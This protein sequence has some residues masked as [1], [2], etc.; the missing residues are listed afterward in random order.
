MF[1]LFKEPKP[2]LAPCPHEKGISENF[3]FKMADGSSEVVPALSL[4]PGEMTGKGKKK[5]QK[6]TSTAPPG[7]WGA[8]RQQA[9]YH[10]EESR[11]AQ[12]PIIDNVV[13]RK[14]E[15]AFH[16]TK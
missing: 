1:S 3:P 16:H 6:K 12:K 5:K 2:A 10:R 14:T 11:D 9:D 7:A 13:K 8:V 4:K 15:R